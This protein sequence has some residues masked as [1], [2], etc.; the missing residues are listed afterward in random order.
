MPTVEDIC[1][2]I[3]G[4]CAS[5]SNP[6]SDTKFEAIGVGQDLRENQDERERESENQHESRS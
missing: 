1:G 2:M 4:V 3:E 6:H 5:C